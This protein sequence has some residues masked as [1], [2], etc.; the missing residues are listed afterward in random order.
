ML[1]I[2]IP[3]LNHLDDLLKP[4]LESVIKYTNLADVEVIVIAD[5]YEDGTKEY[6]ESL[7][8]AF[9]ILRS[10]KPSG[11]ANANNRALAICKGEYIVFLNDDIILL[12]QYKNQ[13]VDLLLAPFNDRSVG[14]TGAVKFTFNCRGIIREVITFWCSMIKREVFE[15]VGYLDE[16]FHPF[17]CE[18]FDYSI[19]AAEAGYRLVQVPNDEPSKYFVTRPTTLFP[20]YHVGSP[21]TNALTTDKK[22]LE[23]K[24]MEIIYERYGTKKMKLNLGCENDIRDGYINCDFY[25][26]QKA[27]MTFDCA[28]LPFDDNSIDEI[29]ANHL[30]EHFDYYDG[31]KVLAEWHRA[32]KPGG[33]LHIETPDLEGLC[34]V[35]LASNEEKRLGLYGVF[36][37]AQWFPGQGHKFLFTEYQLRATLS[38]R[39]FKI[40][41]RLPPTSSYVTT[42][43]W[44]DKEV[45][46]NVEA[47]K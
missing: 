20:I 22:K 4:C 37:A 2:I 16:V 33:R 11:Y 41:N 24:N 35:F 44:L 46:L 25:N 40:I 1:S 13:W 18:D 34:K 7:G 29:L 28:V 30:I 42:C 47:F 12:S 45:L 17:G 23:A 26:N 31:Q 15:K 14:L 9:K 19:R 8:P 10:D 3:T 5:G 27:D 36:F 38:N 39:G 6:V 43:P 21:T 32:L